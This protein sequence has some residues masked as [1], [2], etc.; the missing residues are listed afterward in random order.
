MSGGDQHNLVQRKPKTGSATS[1]KMLGA[2]E[3][4]ERSAAREDAS[5]DENTDYW[6]EER[7]TLL[8]ETEEPEGIMSISY[9]E[10]VAGSPAEVMKAFQT[11][12][13]EQGGFH[14]S[15][16]RHS[17]PPKIIQRGDENG[18]G[19]VR[20]VPNAYLPIVTEHVLAVD[21]GQRIVYS[22]VKNFPASYHRGYVTFEDQNDGTTLVT[23]TVRIVP[24][25]FMGWL[26]RSF[27]TV[28]PTFLRSLKQSQSRL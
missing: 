12:V 24:F 28:F 17:P 14:S 1:G 11:I 26:V 4:E 23:W 5:E 27:I 6:A 19:A 16:L 10:T 9:T 21:P 3:N 15:Y 25:R 2:L 8:A 7:R 22:V 18:V 13:W 20:Q